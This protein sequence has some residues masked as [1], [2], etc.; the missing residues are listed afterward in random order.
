MLRSILLAVVIAL[1]NVS[2]ADAQNFPT[3]PVRFVVGW[4]GHGHTRAHVCG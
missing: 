2:V 4:V 1:A 3:K